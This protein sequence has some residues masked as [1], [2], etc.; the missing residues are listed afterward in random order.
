MDAL[1]SGCNQGVQNAGDGTA[2]AEH[3]Q[4]ALG[5]LQALRLQVPQQTDAVGVVAHCCAPVQ[6]DGVDR[7]TAVC[8][9]VRGADPMVRLGLER[10]GDVESKTSRAEKLRSGGGEPILRRRQ[11]VVAQALSG[12]RGEGA[13]D[14]RRQ[15]VLDRIADH[16]VAIHQR[17]RSPAKVRSSLGP[18]LDDVRPGTTKST[19]P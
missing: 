19:A 4:L 9:G 13:V 2:G 17:K 16:C 15:R 1:H 5:D 10:Q 3:Q 8:G 14:F 18:C 11:F 12:L 6:A 7:A